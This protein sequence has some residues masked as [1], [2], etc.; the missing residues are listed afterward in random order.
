LGT[1]RQNGRLEPKNQPW[2]QKT[3]KNLKKKGAK[4]GPKSS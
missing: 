4:N 1:L 3:G 2:L